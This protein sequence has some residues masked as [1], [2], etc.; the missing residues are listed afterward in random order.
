VRFATDFNSAG[1]RC[2]LKAINQYDKPHFDIHVPITTRPEVLSVWLEQ[3]GVETLN[4]AGNS[5]DTSPGIGQ[6]VEAYLI[7]VF[8]LMDLPF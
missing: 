2:T 4:V 6:I 5:D 3:H 1:E 8:L 7:Q